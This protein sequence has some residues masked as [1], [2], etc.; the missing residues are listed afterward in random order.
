MRGPLKVIIRN[1][2]DKLIAYRFNP[3]IY[4]RPNDEF[5]LD[6]DPFTRHAN[7][8]EAE[9]MLIDA[10]CGRT[11]IVYVLDAEYVTPAAD[12]NIVKLSHAAMR[13]IGNTQPDAW[14]TPIQATESKLQLST[15]FG[16]TGEDMLSEEEKE[17]IRKREGLP[18]EISLNKATE[19]ME[20]VVDV[21]PAPK[22]IQE[23]ATKEE[24]IE[25][26]AESGVV[27]EPTEEVAEEPKKRGRK[28]KEVVSL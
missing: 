26:V 14:T 24:T 21:L 22:Q 16:K 8:S 7:H 11:Q 2:T 12:K 18:K 27:E 19:N 5:I 17:A 9:T 20:K 1:K 10:R 4:V 25:K 3:D 13:R 28:K 15:P 23:D 6:Y